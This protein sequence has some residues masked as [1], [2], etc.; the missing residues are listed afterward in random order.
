MYICTKIF[1]TDGNWSDWSDW[2]NCTKECGGGNQTQTRTC[3][4]P[5]PKH[6]GNNC[7]D[8]NI[9]IASRG[10]NMNPCP[11]RKSTFIF[12]SLNIDTNK[13]IKNS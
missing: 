7:S 9:E 4:N 1:T 10:C 11:I 13:Q 5:T 8:S 2:D 6:G 12:L 3:S